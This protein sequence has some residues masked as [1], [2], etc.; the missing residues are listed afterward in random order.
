MRVY[1][2][3]KLSQPYCYH[4]LQHTENIINAINEIADGMRLSEQ[5]RL[6]VLVAGW[7][8]DV[9]YVC[10]I[11]GHEEVGA[12]MVERFLKDRKVDA[13]DISKVKSCILSTKYPQH[14]GSILEQVI[15]DADLLHLGQK[16]FLHKAALIRE[17]WS[18]TRN[19]NYTDEQWHALNLEFISKHVFHTAYCKKNYDKRKNKNIVFIAKLMKENKKKKSLQVTKE[20]TIES[21]SEKNGKEMKLERGVETVIYNHRGSQKNK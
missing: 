1:L 4:N 20:N 17:E 14:P 8:H 18:L 2:T 9:G 7:F 12:R 10:K 16:D 6:I 3:N 11:E 13:E 19:L 15:C 21:E 5:Q